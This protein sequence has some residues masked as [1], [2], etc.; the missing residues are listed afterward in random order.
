MH[1]RV[2]DALEASYG[3]NAESHAAELAHHFSRAE[4]VLGTE[5]LVHYS[6]LAGEQ[7]LAAYAYE[8]ALTYFERGLV[9]R[10]IT[11]SGTKAAS[12]EESAAL[13][14]GLARAQ[15]AT[16][17]RHQLGKVFTTLSRA[18]EYYAEAGNG[19]QSVADTIWPSPAQSTSWS[20]TQWMKSAKQSL[21]S[22]VSIEQP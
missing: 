7:A 13:L 2:A 10:D 9:A 16:F 3:D 4:A 14:F 5:K 22:S 6:L 17:E 19:A 11:L 21:H 20:S 8:D 18:F 1:G 12:D 15:S